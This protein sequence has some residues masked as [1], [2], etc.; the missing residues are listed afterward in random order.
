M[1]L[2]NGKTTQNAKK[3]RKKRRFAQF[4]LEFK[5]SIE[6]LQGQIQDLENYIQQLQDDNYFLEEENSKLRDQINDLLE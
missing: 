6:T 3:V 2:R 1:L 4:L 5:P